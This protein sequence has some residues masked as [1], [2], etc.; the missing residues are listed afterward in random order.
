[1]IARSWSARARHDD[2]PRYV[3]HARTAVFAH[4]SKIRGYRG[5]LVLTEERTTDVAV[6]VLTFWESMEAVEAFAGSDAAAA[7]VE[8]EAEAALI[9]F[10]R[11]VRHFEVGASQAVWPGLLQR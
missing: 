10:D 8:P 2:A 9:D 5:A 1:M 6:T 7:V 11:R 3:A 4:L